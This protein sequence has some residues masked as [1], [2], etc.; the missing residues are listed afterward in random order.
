[1]NKVDPENAVPRDKNAISRLSDKG[2]I[3]GAREILKP[4][5]DNRD[6][7]GIEGR[8]DV[9]GAPKDKGGLW[10]GDVEAAKAA[11]ARDGKVLLETTKGGRVIDG[12][13]YL[14]EKMPWEQ[15]GKE[16][17]GGVSK[18]YAGTLE[19]EV[20]VY[21]TP[22]AAARGGG[23]VFKTY[24]EPVILENQDRGI[25]TDIIYKIL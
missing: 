1:M 12:W 20:S 3:E 22:E 4:H 21:Q 19:G 13:E 15:G 5:V 2:D 14:N 10:S 17:W 9:G 7:P 8:L 11:A 23:Y 16:L 18:K 24:E 6:V 25:V